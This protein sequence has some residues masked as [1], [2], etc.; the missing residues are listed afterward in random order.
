LLEIQTASELGYSP[1]IVLANRMFGLF[2][3]QRYAAALE[4]AE[5][6][7]QLDQTHGEVYL[8]DWHLSPEETSI[9]SIRPRYYAVQFA[10]DIAQIIGDTQTINTWASRA[11]AFNSDWYQAPSHSIGNTR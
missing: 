9:V 6:L 11:E 10:L 4:A 7:F 3:L 2:L 1:E 8:W 5:Q